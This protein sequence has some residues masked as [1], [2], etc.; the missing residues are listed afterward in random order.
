MV[1]TESDASDRVPYQQFWWV[2]KPGSMPMCQEKLTYF[3]ELSRGQVSPRKIHIG[4]E[5]R[6]VQ[7][8]WVGFPPTRR[9][10]L[11]QSLTL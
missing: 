11:G 10:I 3:S 9:R 8:C 6:Q 7:L 4:F 5:T 1:L 2:S